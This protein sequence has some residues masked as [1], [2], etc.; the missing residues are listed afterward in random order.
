MNVLLDTNVLSEV[1]RPAPDLNVLKWLDTLDEDR[2]FLS[3]VT[4]AELR[5]G[6]A[7]MDAGQRRDALAA[8]IS[9][10][11][12]NRFEGRTIPID[13][14]VALSVMDGFLAATALVRGLVVATRNTK[15]FLPVGVTV[16][17]PWM[18]RRDVV[19]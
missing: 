12:P 15:D 6:I 7:L 5:R 19:C 3:V 1:R 2:A 17:N 8:W 18:N 9:R 4:I 13:S 11:L 16:L 10:D 14:G